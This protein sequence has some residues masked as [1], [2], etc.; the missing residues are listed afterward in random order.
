[1][2]NI[3]TLSN[4]YMPTFIL[5]FFCIF[6]F[7]SA[8]SFVP[9]EFVFKDC[10]VI[11]IKKEDTFSTLAEN[12]LKDPSLGWMISEFNQISSLVPG[13][14]VIIPMKPFRK[15]GL[16]ASGYQTVPVLCYNRFSRNWAGRRTVKQSSFDAQ[17]R[18]LKEN[19]YHPIT[20]NQWLEFLNF[21]DQIPEKSVIITI[22]DGWSSTYQIAYPILK[23]YNFPAIVFVYT[24]LIGSTKAMTWEQL[25]EMQQNG[26]DIQ[27]K[28]NTRRNLADQKKNE[29]FQ[30]YIKSIE[31]EITESSMAIKKNLNTRSRCIAYPLG[32]HNHLV[33]FL[34][35]KNDIEAGLTLKDGEN[36]FFINKYQVHRSIIYGKDNL[37][38]FKA[39][40]V[41]FHES[42]LK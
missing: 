5:P 16:K 42:D 27:C 29:T 10:A 38:S 36:P 8:C 40:L 17:M 24:N 23:K 4:I 1:M 9:R 39:V 18:Y 7:I 11:R 2:Q 19:G 22:D 15:G 21:K 26:I 41:T 35:K 13:Q 3:K 12:Y 34:L 14:K 31:R 32:D 28:A 20:L 6:L 25:K 37:K 33:R 30:G